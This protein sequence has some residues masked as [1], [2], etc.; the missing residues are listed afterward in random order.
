MREFSIELPFPARVLFPNARPN[1]HVKARE[2]KLHRYWSY[3][4]TRAANVGEVAPKDVIEYRITY[5]PKT[6]R[7]RDEDGIISSCK[8]YL[9]GVAQALGIDDHIFRH[10]GTE[11]LP[12]KAPG[13]LVLTFR[14]EEQNE[15]NH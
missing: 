7:R 11:A 14:W 2:V 1:W 15:A 8:S 9:D 12:A 10:R 3:V 6:N 4:A 5:T 13:S